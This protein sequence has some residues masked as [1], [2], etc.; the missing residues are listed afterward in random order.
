MI[1]AS[2]EK[3]DVLF[4]ENGLSANSSTKWVIKKK[5]NEKKIGCEKREKK[6]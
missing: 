5:K 3:W 6:E 4:L 2:Y 1:D